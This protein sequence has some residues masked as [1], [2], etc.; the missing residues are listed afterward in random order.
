M[1]SLGAIWGAVRFF[2]PLRRH[3]GFVFIRVGSVKAGQ[4]LAALIKGE[5]AIDS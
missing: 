1:S 3:K 5:L 2:S 4:A